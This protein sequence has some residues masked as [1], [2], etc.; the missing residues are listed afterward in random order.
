MSRLR[1]TLALSIVFVLVISGAARA[2]TLDGVIT[3]YDSGNQGTD[4]TVKTSDGKSHDLWFDNMKKP[5]FE[6]KQLPWCPEFPCTGWPSELVLNKTRVR[7]YTVNQTVSGH[8]VVSPT[9]IELLH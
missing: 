8:A 3:S 5:S 2:G 9:R 6:G 4:M 1:N 7:V